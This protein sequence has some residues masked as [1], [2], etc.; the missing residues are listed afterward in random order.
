MVLFNNV[1]LT[2]YLAE[3]IA[4]TA[5]LTTIHTTNLIVLVKYHDQT[6]DNN[7]KCNLDLVIKAKTSIC[8]I[9]YKTVKWNDFITILRQTI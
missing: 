4:I 6:Q 8:S 7:V 5:S 2:S 9:I 3:I 1:S